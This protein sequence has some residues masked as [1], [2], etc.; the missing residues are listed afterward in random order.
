[1][2]IKSRW[3]RAEGQEVPGTSSHLAVLVDTGQSPSRGEALKVPGTLRNG[4]R[5][6]VD[7]VLLLEQSVWSG[8]LFSY[9]YN[10]PCPR[11]CITFFFT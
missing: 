2:I 10:E 7:P 6:A 9:S 1:M 4:Y 5:Y 11:Q 8:E 3:Y